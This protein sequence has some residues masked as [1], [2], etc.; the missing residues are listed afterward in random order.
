MSKTINVSYRHSEI[1]EIRKKEDERTIT[2]VAS[3]STRDSAGTVLNQDNWDLTRFN[4]NGIIGYQHKV[5]GGWDD[6]DNPDN[7]I[8]K[9]H[10]YVEDGKLMVDI[11]FE[12]K[13]INELAEKIYQK[14]LFGSLRAV[15][16]G[17]LPIGKGRFGE[18][19][20]AETYYFAGQQLLE[21]S[22]V[23]IPAN[24][25]ALRKSMEAENDFLEAERKR[26]LE[27]TKVEEPAP[28]PQEEPDQRDLD[29]EMT[30]LQARAY[31][32]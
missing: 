2:F 32:A 23:N 25:N 8:G 9:G 31:L 5:Y 18:G 30:L 7:V 3:D 28:E 27:E 29:L 14:V 4:S 1:R 6:T 22:V 12:P 11:T 24:P 21:V 19:A 15:S 17:F 13:E 16:V 10:A 20:D 26:L